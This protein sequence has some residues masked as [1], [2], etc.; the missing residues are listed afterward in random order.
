MELTV[1]TAL[2]TFVLSMAVV[3][4]LRSSRIPNWLTVPSMVIAM[5]V[6]TY[7]HSLG[8]LLF[9][10]TGLGAGLGLFLLLYL[11]GSI[12][13][14]D[15]KLMAAVGAMLGA[16]GAL[17]SSVLAMLVG[18]SYALGA[19]IYQWGF[20][21][22]GR[23]LISAAQ[24]ALQTSGKVW[25]HELQLPFRLRYGLAIAGGTLLFLTGLHPF[26]G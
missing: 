3:T 18:G 6:H 22:T 20:V 12:G 8:G 10:L 14:G 26:G 17:G 19:M 24:R 1:I 5:G 16:E 23:K 25:A 11:M 4:D 13:A 21:G 9:S 15:V 7:M 2:V